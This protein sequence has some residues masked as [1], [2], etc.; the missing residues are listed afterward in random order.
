MEMELEEAGNG[1]VESTVHGWRRTPGLGM[2]CVKGGR[3]G[4]KT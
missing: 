4:G 2:E 3:E 1:P